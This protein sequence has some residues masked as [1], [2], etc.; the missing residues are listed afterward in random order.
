MRKLNNYR[1]K[2]AILDQL[3]AELQKLEEDQILKADLAFKEQLIGLMEEY[4]ITPSE[5]AE[6]IQYMDC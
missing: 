4:S 5:T 1:Q 3:A 6:L 2:K